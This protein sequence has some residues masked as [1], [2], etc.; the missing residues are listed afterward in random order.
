MYQGLEYRKVAYGKEAQGW[1]DGVYYPRI[2][3]LQP[4]ENVR[5]GED[6]LLML[7]SRVWQ[8]IEET[9]FGIYYYEETTELVTKLEGSNY[10]VRALLANPGKSA[11]TC[12]I[13]L[14]NIVKRDG[15]TVEPGEEKE[16]SFTACMTDGNFALRFAVGAMPDIHGEVMEGDVYLRDLDIVPEPAKRRRE[17]PCVFL[18][19]DSTVQSYNR[20]FY[21]QTGWG[22]VLCRFFAGAEQVTVSQTENCDYG[23]AMTYELP[24]LIIEN[25]S[26]GGRSARSFYDEGKLDQALEV[27]CPGDF[28]LVQF[29]HN[30]NNKLRPNRYISTEEYP[31]FLKLYLEA[32]ERRGAQCVFVTAV[33]MRYAD[34]NGVFSISFDDYR[35]KMME[36]AREKKVPLLDLGQR[37]TEFLNEIGDEE[38]KNIYLWAAEGEYPDGAYAA[39]VSDNA[40]LQEYGAKVYADMVARMIAE[41][42]EDDRLD[43]L[44]R[45]ALP[46]PVNEIGKPVR[47]NDAA[48]SGTSVSGAPV[49]DVVTGFVAQEIS[50]DNGRGSFLLNWNLL[51][52]ASSYIVYARKAGE[53]DFQAV[54][55]VTKEE[56]E[57]YATLPFS[58]EAGH[59]WQYRVAAVFPDGREGQVSR[60]VQVD[61]KTAEDRAAEKRILFVDDA[62]NYTDDM[63]VIERL[64]T[65]GI[66]RRDGK[67][68][69]QLSGDGEYK[70]PGG[71]VE[72]G[73]SLVQSLCREVAEETGL[74]VDEESVS[75]CGEIL[76]IRRDLFERDKKYIKHSHVY[77][78]GVREERVETRMTES[79]VRRGFHP[80][81]ESLDRIIA[82][83]REVLKEEWKLRDT[84]L[85][86]L[87][88]E[89]G[90]IE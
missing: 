56:K 17:K 35:R 78:C 6:G 45:L 1:T 22:Q 16:V 13:R 34:E 63:P 74:V 76:E 80:V 18:I 61:L 30:D 69:M 51:P 82:G 2:A 23:L 44:K 90:L 4:A 46:V 81:W 25:R 58:A 11:Y 70:I 75:Y 40:H 54:R 28:M 19:S 8:E 21:P 37:S 9:G 49:T 60:E 53:A 88:R 79:E 12:H 20:R 68:A 72:E 27:M 33:T 50:V 3:Q 71:G 55:T 57:A 59:L 62:K 7:H 83:N 14:N 87:L 77:L 10:K 84:K 89:R 52:G 85:L 41:Y 26:I 42:D 39:G 24:E 5:C 31:A 29:A 43:V 32:C 64:A 86:E 65:R 48:A 15:V 67:Y 73:E 66:I 47:K 38:S 36:Y